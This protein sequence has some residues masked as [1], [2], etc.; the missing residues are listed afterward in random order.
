MQFIDLSQPLHDRM[1][2]YPGDPDISIGSALTVAADG[3]AVARLDFGSHSGTHLDA[4]AHVISGGRTVDRIPLELL[5]GPA[6]ILRAP[7]ARAGERIDISAIPAG[8]PEQLPQIVCVQTGWDRYFG[9]GEMLRHPSL[10][11]ELAELLWGRGARVLCVDTLSPDP[12]NTRELQRSESKTTIPDPDAQSNRPMGAQEMGSE[13]P[14]HEFWLGRD[15]VIVENLVG[16][17]RLPDEVQ[18]SLLPLAIRG[19]DG[20]PIR[21]I[22]RLS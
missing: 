17:H 20:A 6:A 16:L 22:A 10:A 2:A 7:E 15:G 1:P 3:V 4:P 8:I 12:T 13:F 19:G 9:G 11:L 14:V 18:L 21:A 5:V